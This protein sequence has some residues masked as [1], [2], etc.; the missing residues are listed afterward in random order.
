VV[1]AQFYII[2]PVL[3]LL[4]RNFPVRKTGLIIFGLLFFA[5]ML[6]RQLAWPADVFVMPDYFTLAAKELVGKVEQFPCFLDYFAFGVG[7]ACLYSELENQKSLLRA[8]GMLG[9]LGILLLAVYI[10]FYAEWSYGFAIKSN[11]TRWSVEFNHFLPGLAGFF[12]LFFVFDP[13]A[14]GSR[15]IAAPWLRFIGIV[16]FEWFLFHWPFTNF[17]ADWLGHTQG[18][19]IF[20]LLKT[21]GPLALTFIFS[22]LVYR[23]FSL[24]IL[25]RI[26]QTIRK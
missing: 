19:A 26:R 5:P 17:F 20:Y 10:G 22:V 21:V 23:F 13:S 14:L 9:Y 4:T 1:E 7:F 18:N 16:S 6:G 8:L 2:L 3:F 24:P 12:L 25:N 15:I 11:P